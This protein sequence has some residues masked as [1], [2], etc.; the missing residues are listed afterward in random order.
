MHNSSSHRQLSNLQVP[1]GNVK[2]DITKNLQCKSLPVLQ[3]DV[4]SEEFHLKRNA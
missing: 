2:V 1:L 4:S 3:S